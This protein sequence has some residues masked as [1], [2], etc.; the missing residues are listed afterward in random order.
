MRAP[1]SWYNSLTNSNQIKSMN[2]Q[3]FFA[4]AD[5]VTIG[6]DPEMADYSNPRGDIAGYAAY[7]YAEDIN[8]FRRRMH[9]KT[10]RYEQDALPNAVA[11]AA[12]LTARLANYDKDP[13][14]FKNWEEARPVYGSHAYELSLVQ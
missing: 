3:T 13:V 12:A 9:V 7:V 10:E 4:A 8:G 6:Q 1:G 14:N 2:I 5:L 11:I